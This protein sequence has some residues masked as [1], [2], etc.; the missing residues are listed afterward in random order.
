MAYKTMFLPSN[1]RLQ[2]RLRR[3]PVQPDAP[4]QSWDR[5][6]WEPYAAS[7]QKN[8]IAIDN[9]CFYR[10]SFPFHALP[11]WKLVSAMRTPASFR[12][13]PDIL[14][15]ETGAGR[16]GP[17]PRRLD[18]ALP[19]RSLQCPRAPRSAGSGAPAS[20]ALF[21]IPGANEPH[22]LHTVQ[23]RPK[24]RFETGKTGPARGKA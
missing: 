5:P 6:R 12:C 18:Q 14:F 16:V 24:S 13:C 22:P 3:Y 20:S 7:A 2:G 23:L 9:S 11:A 17:R 19:G 21:R 1:N 4:S 10:I 8:E 15:P